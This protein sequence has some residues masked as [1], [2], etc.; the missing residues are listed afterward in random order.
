MNLLIRINIC[1]GILVSFFSCTNKVDNTKEMLKNAIP[2]QTKELE[3]DFFLGKPSQITICND[4]LVITDNIEEKVL[5]FYDIQDNLFIG[6]GL[7]VGQGPNEVITP[8]LL[9]RSSE[10]KTLSIMQRQDGHYMEYDVEIL[11]E[12]DATPNRSLN[13]ENTDRFVQTANGFITSGPNEGGSINILNAT[14]EIIKNQNIYPRY[15]NDLEQI[16]ARYVYGQGHIAYNKE[17]NVMAFASYFSGE[18]SFYRLRKDSLEKLN[19]FDF[20]LSP[21]FRN[22]IK[23]STG[24][25]KIE[26]TDIEYFSDIYATPNYFYALYTGMQRRDKEAGADSY[27]FKFSV[28]GELIAC[29][30]VDH[31]IL[32]LCVQGNDEK[33]YAI[34]FSEDMDYVL[35]EAKL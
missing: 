35:I 17:N 5:A 31:R 10:S 24:R 12:G 9:S 16:D 25:A 7:T 14:G 20:S 26:R 33:M 1:A 3:I 34:G 32:S 15:V 21:S 11:S 6:R 22:R 8:L 19:E 23:N 28:L 30:K 4:V 29:Y 18:A 13:L 27:V 2:L